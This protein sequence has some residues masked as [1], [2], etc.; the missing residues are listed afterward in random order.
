[1]R[2]F[3]NSLAFRA[4]LIGV[5]L[6][7]CLAASPLSATNSS[8]G[9]PLDGTWA[10]TLSIDP[11]PVLPETILLLGTFTRD[12]TFVSTSDLPPIPVVDPFV[13]VGM[14]QGTWERDTGGSYVLR[15]WRLTFWHNPDGLI[16]G[17]E[18]GSLFGFSR[19]KATIS[20]DHRAGL[21]EGEITLQLLA[22][23]FTP[24]APEATGTL[25]GLRVNPNPQLNE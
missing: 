18:D 25:Q 22:P 10:I 3:K 16:P 23:D 2:L 14:G 5:L 12:G 7:L 11:N 13:K 17:V 20:V 1:M 15:T 8:S 4:Q 21:L 9:Q 6:A 24:V 19:G